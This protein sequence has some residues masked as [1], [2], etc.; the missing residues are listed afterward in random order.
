MS[1]LAQSLPLTDFV[2]QQSRSF[3]GLCV[4]RR[5]MNC[6]FPVTDSQPMATELFQSPLYRS[7]TVFRSISH[8]LRHFLSSALA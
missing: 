5:L 6:L 4:P 7:G 3:E 8:L 2:I 1:T